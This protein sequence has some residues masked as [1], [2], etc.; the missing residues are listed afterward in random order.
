MDLYPV[1]VKIPLA[2]TC[3]NATIF[4]FDAIKEEVASKAALFFALPEQ[5]PINSNEILNEVKRRILC[6]VFIIIHSNR[7]PNVCFFNLK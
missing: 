7:C 5:A 3:P 2:F 6:I 1:L 4:G